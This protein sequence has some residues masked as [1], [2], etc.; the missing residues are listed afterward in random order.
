MNK[1]ALIGWA[2]V[3]WTYYIQFPYNLTLCQRYA[4]KGGRNGTHDFI[5]YKGDK[6]HD[7]G[8]TDMYPRTEMRV[9]TPI[10]SQGSGKWSMTGYFRA[11]PTSTAASIMQL[12][13]MSS[14][15][16]WSG[17][18]LFQLRLFN[19]QLGTPS[20]NGQQLFPNVEICRA[21][22]SF[23][24]TVDMDLLRFSLAIDNVQIFDISAAPTTTS[25]PT[26]TPT[27]RPTL[28]PVSGTA[29]PA[30][31]SPTASPIVLNSVVMKF[32]PYD[33]PYDRY[34]PSIRNEIFYKGLTLYKWVGTNKK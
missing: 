6:R 31:R 20:Y 11:T 30:P 7:I 34:N 22:R 19:C 26:Q 4:N 32:G 16:R 1:T 5:I 14:G 18:N 24:L 33:L 17:F 13:P 29:P 23:N 28:T 2:P 8:S 9:L 3:E 27:F 15:S 12:F 21:Y 25:S 10:M